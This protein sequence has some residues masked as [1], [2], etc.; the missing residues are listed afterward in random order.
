MDVIALCAHSE[1]NRHVTSLASSEWRKRANCIQNEHFVGRW[2]EP[3]VLIGHSLGADNQIRVDRALN[4]G[5]VPVD[6]LVLIDP[7]A[8]PHI[9]PNVRRCVN[10]FKSHRVSDAVPVFRGTRVNPDRAQTV[11][12]NIDLRLIPVGFDASSITHFNIA[13]VTGVQDMVLAEIAKT[14]PLR[15]R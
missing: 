7:D 13:Q 8:L 6:L 1:L 12:K 2:S 15:Y 11:V 5:G 4:G 3:V 9:P 10:I 14:C